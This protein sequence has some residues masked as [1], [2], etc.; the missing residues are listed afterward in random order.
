VSVPDTAMCAVHPAARASGVCS[1]CGSFVCGECLTNKEQLCPPCVERAEEAARK[2]PRADVLGWLLVAI[3]ALGGA[4]YFFVPQGLSVLISIVIV[5]ATAILAAIDARDT[6]ESPGGV[7]ALHSLLWLV[8]YPLYLYRRSKSGR[9]SR[10]WPG[11][12]AMLLF[13]TG[14]IGQAFV[15]QD[16]SEVRCKPTGRLLR[17]GYRCTIDRPSGHQTVETC[18]DLVVTCDAATL[19]AHS[20]GTAKAHAQGV[21]DVPLS[22]FATQGTKCNAVRQTELQNITVT[23]AK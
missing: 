18:W 22:A 7:A 19:T 10:L 13:F 12:W 9:P 5:A 23:V 4:A 17:D 21:V 15:G 14:V 16:R 8:G 6:Q 20:C 2:Q 1:R 3:P 11:L